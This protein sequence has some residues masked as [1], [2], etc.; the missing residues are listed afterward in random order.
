VDS[1]AA[2]EDAGLIRPDID[3]AV[4][5]SAENGSDAFSRKLSL[6]SVTCDTITRAVVRSHHPCRVIERSRP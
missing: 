2:I 1:P 4:H 6:S 5:A 3:G